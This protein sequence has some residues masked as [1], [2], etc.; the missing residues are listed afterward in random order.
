MQPIRRIPIGKVAILGILTLSIYFWIWVFKNSNDLHRNEG[1]HTLWQL[2][3][4]LGIPTGGLTL[5]VLYVFNTLQANNIRKARGMPDNV[6][7]WVAFGLYVGQYVTGITGLIAPFVW[8]MYSNEL[9][10]QATLGEPA[11]LATT[12]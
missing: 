11:P 10:E 2:W 5:I 4:W 12:A 1:G 8:A 7:G 6:T 9:A 3:F